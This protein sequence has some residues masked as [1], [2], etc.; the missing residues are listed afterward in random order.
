MCFDV[1][2]RQFCY[3]KPVPEIAYEMLSKIRISIDSVGKFIQHRNGEYFIFEEMNECATLFARLIS[4][5]SFLVNK[6]QT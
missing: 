1:V 3:I 6:V 2:L 5:F 4:Y